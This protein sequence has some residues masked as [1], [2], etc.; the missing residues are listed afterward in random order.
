[1]SGNTKGALRAAASR[2]GISEEEYRN[3]LTAG[4]KWC[5]GCKDWHSLEKFG[6][7]SS[8]TDGHSSRCTEGRSRYSKGLYIP[9]PGPKGKPFPKKP[10]R[11][12]DKRQARRTVNFLVESG[13]LPRPVDLPCFDCGDIN[14]DRKHEYDHHLG[15][16]PEHHLHVQAVCSLCHIQRTI[17]RGE[18]KGAKNKNRVD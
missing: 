17:K 7:D 8:R 14:T 10:A 5:I 12:G 16:A 18:I 13:K 11:H 3:K 1:M 2:I 6:V 9:H 4:L 15:Y